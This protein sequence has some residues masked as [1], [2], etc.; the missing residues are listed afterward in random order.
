[1]N[2][3]CR[4]MAYNDVGLYGFEEIIHFIMTAFN[5]RASAIRNYV[6]F[7][8]PWSPDVGSSVT[9]NPEVVHI[10]PVQVE[11]AFM[12]RRIFQIHVIVARQGKYQR[13]LFG[14]KNIIQNLVF[15]LKN[16]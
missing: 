3:V 11:V 9:G 2:A 10:M 8:N 16:P 13:I 5:I 15:L 6:T 1:M 7:G 14:C 4:L 12:E